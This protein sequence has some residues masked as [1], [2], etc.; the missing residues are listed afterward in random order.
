MVRIAAGCLST[1]GLL[2]A[3]AGLTYLFRKYERLPRIELSGVLDQPAE[4]GEPENYL[5]VGID[6]AANLPRGDAARAGRGPHVAVGHDHD[7][8]HRPGLAAP[9]RC[10]CPATCT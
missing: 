9:R 5:I 1:I 4:S 3:A 7:P 2:A 6:S 10:R 8:A